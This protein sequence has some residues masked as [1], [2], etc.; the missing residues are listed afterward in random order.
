VSDFIRLAQ[1]DPSWYDEYRSHLRDPWNP[2]RRLPGGQERRFTDWIQSLPWFADMAESSGFNR[3]PG[4]FG[5]GL[6]QHLTRP[7]ESLYDYRRAWLDGQ[8]PGAE[9]NASDGFQHWN[10]VASDG[11]FLKAPWHPTTW[12]E[13]YSRAY[14]GE[15][16]G[17]WRTPEEARD[18]RPRFA[19]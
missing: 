6:A 9:R 3:D 17:R 1:G 13:F 15:D 19:F 10:S 18:M 16:P 4:I 2:I 7:E 8:G 12:M 11:T 14:P 5:P